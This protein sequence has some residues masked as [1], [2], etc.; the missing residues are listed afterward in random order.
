MCDSGIWDFVL[1]TSLDP[2]MTKA[3]PPQ[4]WLR[5]MALFA[6]GFTCLT[7]NAVRPGI[8]SQTR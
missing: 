1:G 6:A 2:Q 7:G 5:T 4:P 3:H 8:K